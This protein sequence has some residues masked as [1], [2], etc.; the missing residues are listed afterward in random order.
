VSGE[1]GWWLG[2]TI[3][4]AHSKADVDAHMEVFAEFVTTV[5]A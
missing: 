5:T 2:P 4:V 1:S 3:S